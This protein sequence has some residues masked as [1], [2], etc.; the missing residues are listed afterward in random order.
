M[1]C[2]EGETGSC[3][4]TC[5]TC[6]FGTTEEISIKAEDAIDIKEEIAETVSIP[7]IKTEHEV[8]F[9]GVCVCV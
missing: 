2:V 4:E 8:W 1:C 6:D 9:L 3:I 5:L 7:S